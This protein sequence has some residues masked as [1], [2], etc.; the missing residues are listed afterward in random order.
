M[1]VSNISVVGAEVLELGAGT[2]DRPAT[3]SSA[4][5]LAEVDRLAEQVEDPPERHR[6][7]RDRDRA[8]GVDHLGAA[9][10]TVGRVHRDG[11]HAVVAE[12]LLDLAAR[13]RRWRRCSSSS[14][15]RA[16]AGRLIVIAC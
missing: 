5:S 12:L 3:V 4:S 8:A 10:K 11:A 16:A 6:A 14:S 15:A 1:P 9:G 7:D 13:A 2:V